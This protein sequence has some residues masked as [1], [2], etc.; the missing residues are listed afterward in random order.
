LKRWRFTPQKPA[1]I[2]YQMDE[3]EVEEWTNTTFQKSFKSKLRKKEVR[4]IFAKNPEFTLRIFTG[5]S[6]SSKGKIPVIKTTVSRL[7]MNV[8]SI[9]LM[10]VL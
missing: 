2:A 6:Y 7:K 5:K 3:T 10:M 8:I 9:Y 1:K 4:S